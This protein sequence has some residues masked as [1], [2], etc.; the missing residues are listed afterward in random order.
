M[1]L[2]NSAVN[3]R[4]QYLLDNDHDADADDDYDVDLS[5]DVVAITVDIWKYNYYW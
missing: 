1:F 4:Y 3:K 2:N 5:R